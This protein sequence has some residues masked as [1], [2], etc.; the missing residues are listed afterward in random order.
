MI[1]TKAWEW[2]LGWIFDQIQEGAESC[3]RVSDGGGD[4][5][6]PLSHHPMDSVTM[7]I[8]I[9]WT[10]P[11]ARP[12]GPH[13]GTSGCGAPARLSVAAAGPVEPVPSSC[14]QHGGMPNK[15][16]FGAY[17]L[18]LPEVLLSLNNGV[19]AVSFQDSCEGSVESSSKC[20]AQCLR[21]VGAQWP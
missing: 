12:R 10:P 19:E 16:L 2:R 18:L 14:C 20:V 17:F 21:R 13:S 5:T 15:E 6:C 4:H 7:P 8:P 9:L 3:Q 1:G 11:P